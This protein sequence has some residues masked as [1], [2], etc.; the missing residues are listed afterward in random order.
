MASFGMRS[1]G[2]D[3]CDLDVV[4]VGGGIAGLATAYELHRR[5]VPFRRCSS[6]PTRPGGVILSEEVDG[7]TIDAGPDALLIQKPDGIKLCQELGLGDRLV[8]TMPPRLAFIQR[9]RTAASAAGRVGARHPDARR[10][11]RPHPPLFVAGQAAHGRRALRAGAARRRRRIDRRVHDA[12]L[13]TR[14]DRPISPNRCWRA[15]TRATSIGC[16]S[17]RCFRDSSD[18]ERTA[19]QPASRVSRSA[20]RRAASTPEG[21]FKSLPGGLSEMVRALV[22]ALPPGRVQTEHGRHAASRASAASDAVPRRD[23][24][25]REHRHEARAVVLATPAYVTGALLRDRDAE[26]ARPVRRSPLRV[27]RHRRARVSPRRRRAPAR[28]DRAS[29]CRAPRTAASSPRRGCRRNGRIA[30]RKARC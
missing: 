4:I 6:A 12:P 18:A 28:T 8:S 7:F 1:A 13:R 27:D 16:R 19:R 26:L 2:A 22:A 24:R 11:V 23:S 21:A 30:R 29:S 25:R 10:S 9:G 15:S 5:G 17:A 14:G 20:G 3:Q